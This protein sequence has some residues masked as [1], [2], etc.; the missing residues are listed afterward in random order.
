[1]TG[2]I[3]SSCILYGKLKVHGKTYLRAYLERS[4]SKTVMTRIFHETCC[5]CYN[6]DIRVNHTE[7]MLIC[8]SCGFTE[9]NIDLNSTSYTQSY[10]PAIHNTRTHTEILPRKFSNNIYK[11]CNHFRFWL[12]R[13]QGKDRKSIC[14]KDLKTILSHL[15]LE[16]GGL[17]SYEDIKAC[18]K[19]L[20]FTRYYTNIFY[21]M[22]LIYGQPIIELTKE[23][24]DLLLRKFVMI[25]ESYK[26]HCT[27]RSNMLSY[28]FIL[29]KLSQ[30][31]G[32]EDLSF[33]LPKFKSMEKTRL[34]DSIWKNIC[35]DLNWKYIKSY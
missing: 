12:Q 35:Q 8:A 15:H 20:G 16:G 17:I 26:K 2:H 9:T 31:E 1:M 30:I 29:M 13:V 22:S 27:T 25:Q 3:L 21:I 5:Y 32:W 34:A 19:H 24:E 14:Q 4:M 33:M 10:G 6:H 11:R 18:L 23:H 7:G 28:P